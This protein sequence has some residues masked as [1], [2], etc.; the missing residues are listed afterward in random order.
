[1]ITHLILMNL[2]QA[3]DSPFVTAQVLSL[4]SQVP[5]LTKVR[6]GP[7]AVQLQTTWDLG[8]VMTFVDA[9]AVRAY[10][11]HPAHLEVGSKVREMIREMAT[12]DIGDDLSLE[13]SHDDVSKI[14]RS[15]HEQ[16]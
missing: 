8:F 11:T 9:D 7:S 15:A 3:G 1:M 10:Q 13:T 2:S 5:G 16:R 6:G 14:T 12:C 4:E